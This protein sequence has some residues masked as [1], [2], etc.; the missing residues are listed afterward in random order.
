MSEP[1]VT[2]SGESELAIERSAVLVLRQPDDE[3]WGLLVAAFRKKSLALLFVSDELLDSGLD[4]GPDARG[5]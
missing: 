3:F 2:G 4:D 1:T 5:Q